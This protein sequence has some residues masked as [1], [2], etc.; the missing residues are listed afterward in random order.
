MVVDMVLHMVLLNMASTKQV[1]Q[2]MK[3]LLTK[4]LLL[5]QRLQKQKLKQQNLLRQRLLQGTNFSNNEVG[6]RYS[7]NRRSRI[8]R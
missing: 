7:G 2:S 4:P 1:V 8:Y 5:L 6:R 3:K